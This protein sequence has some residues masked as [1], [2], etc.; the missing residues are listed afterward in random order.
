METITENN[1]QKDSYRPYSQLELR[2]KRNNN[3]R[4]I[5]INN[6]LYV[7]HDTCR[8]FYKVKRYSKKERD[9]KESGSNYNVG[10]CSLCWSMKNNY[11]DM[12]EEFFENTLPDY[13]DIFYPE[14]SDGE[15]IHLTP[16]AVDIENTVLRWINNQLY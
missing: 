10:N 8:H 6:D 1:T 15:K 2:D 3:M 16:Y 12:D 13:L 14:A 11:R 5:K 9:I 7:L 4:R